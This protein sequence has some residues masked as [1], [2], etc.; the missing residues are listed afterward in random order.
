MRGMRRVAGGLVVAAAL[1]GST[2][3]SASAM[4]APVCAARLAPVGTA[5]C[6]F[7]E[8]SGY[9]VISVEPVESTVT[10]TVTCYTPWGPNT[11]SRT[12]SSY[13]SFIT[14]TY[15]S[16]TLSLSSSSA[17]A[18]GTATAS[19]WFPIEGDPA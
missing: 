4:V 5:S 7:Q 18:V 19:P 3:G 6:G 2:A 10:A 14:S 15:G 1:A 13:G 16:C 12:F 8:N 17:T 11:T 9:A